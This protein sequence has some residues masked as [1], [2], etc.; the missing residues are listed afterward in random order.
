VGLLE[1]LQRAPVARA[2]LVGQPL[3]LGEPRRF[4]VDLPGVRE[5]PALLTQRA[6]LL[7]QSQHVVALALA[8][9]QARA[10]HE[11]CDLLANQR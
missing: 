5:A 3:G 9:S 10:G 2:R 4:A 6:R 8:G 11:E 7:Q 1:E